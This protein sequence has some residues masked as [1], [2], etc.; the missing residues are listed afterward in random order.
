MTVRTR[1]FLGMIALLGF[2]AA[3]AIGAMALATDVFVD[4][5]KLLELAFYIVAGFAWILP[6]GFIVAWMQRV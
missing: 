4:M 2:I 5:P 6:A 3:Y 1:K